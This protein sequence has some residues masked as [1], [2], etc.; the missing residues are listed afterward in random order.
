M[1]AAIAE[2]PQGPVF[3]KLTAPKATTDAAE[4]AFREMLGSLKR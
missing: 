1:L 2:A 3:F 4:A